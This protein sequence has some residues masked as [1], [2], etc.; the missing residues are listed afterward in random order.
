MNR[1]ITV[2]GWGWCRGRLSPGHSTTTSPTGISQRACSLY[3][4]KTLVI[5]WPFLKRHREVDISPAEWNAMKSHTDVILCHHYQFSMIYTTAEFSLSSTCYVALSTQWRKSQD[6]TK[7]H[8]CDI[9]AYYMI[10]FIWYPAYYTV[11][12]LIY[13]YRV[14]TFRAG[15]D[16]H[17]S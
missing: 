10:Y 6:T 16:A 8:R 11:D 1:K 17:S 3:D 14:R 13:K 4:P 12:A 5:I 2:D 7:L 15:C 9:S